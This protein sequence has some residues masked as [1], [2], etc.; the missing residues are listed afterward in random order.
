MPNT[1]STY[2]GR[3]IGVVYER[4]RDR[5]RISRSIKFLALLFFVV[6]GLRCW[7]G[8]KEAHGLIDAAL[9]AIAGVIFAFSGDRYGVS[10]SRHAGLRVLGRIIS[11]LFGAAF[12]IAA[13]S[14]LT[15]K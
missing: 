8:P 4:Y 1:P 5:A 6:F 15:G 10:T 9:F 3:R 14:I 11:L 12:T 13:I 2:Q 7:L